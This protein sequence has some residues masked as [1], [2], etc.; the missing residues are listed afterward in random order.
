MVKKA[1]IG[2]ILPDDGPFDYEWLRLEPLLAGTAFAGGK[3][4]TDAVWWFYLFWFPDNY[5]GGKD[6]IGNRHAVSLY[7]AFLFF[8]TGTVSGVA[9]HL[10]SWSVAGLFLAQVLFAPF[11]AADPTAS[12]RSRLPATD[13]RHT[14]CLR[15]ML[16]TQ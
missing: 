13:E 6:F 5:Q 12:G 14:I 1:A 9:V 11:G 7:P 3:F 15:S 4:L 8:I 2:V 10:V 16:R